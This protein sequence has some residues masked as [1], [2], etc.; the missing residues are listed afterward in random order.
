MVMG[1]LSDSLIIEDESQA[2]KDG[3]KQKMISEPR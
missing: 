2:R 3:S 1:V